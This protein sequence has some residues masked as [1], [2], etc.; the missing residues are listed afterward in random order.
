M[1]G[2][3][4]FTK[5]IWLVEEYTHGLVFEK[6]TSAVTAAKLRVCVR[7]CGLV[8]AVNGETVKEVRGIQEYI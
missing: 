4:N 3:R 8:V 5:T 7:V 1:C 2:R 6:S